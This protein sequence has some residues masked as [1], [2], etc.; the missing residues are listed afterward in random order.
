MGVDLRRA[1]AVTSLLLAL[2][3]PARA[4][5]PR[6]FAVVV[7]ANDPGQAALPALSYADDDAV[8]NAELL[9]AQGAEVRLLSDLDA[10][11]SRLYPW[12][13]ARAQ[14]PTRAGVLGA[15]RAL[16]AHMTQAKQRGESVDFFFVY[17][18]HG[19]VA[20][21]GQGQL[22]LADGAL[23]RTDLYEQLLAPSPA[24]FNHVIVDAC[25]AYEFVSGRGSDADLDR[26]LAERA[27]RYLDAQSLDRFPNT[28]VI[29]A[30][31]A[32]ARTHEWSEYQGGVFSHEVRSALLGAADL[33][34]DGRITYREAGAFV[35][36][37]NERVTHTKARLDV[38]VHPPRRAP[39]RPLAVWSGGPSLSIERPV[40]GH[41]WLE[42]ERGVRIGEA[43]K[44]TEQP[45][46]LALIPRE[47]YY[48]TLG[49]D[50]Y[51]FTA[52]GQATVRF[53]DLTR[54]AGPSLRAR[55]SIDDAFRRGL[56]AVPFGHASVEAY[57][58]P[59]ADA[60]VSEITGARPSPSGL[61]TAGY[62]LAIGAVVAGLTSAGCYLASNDAY[63]RF[64][65]AETQDAQ[66]RWK[67]RTTTYDWL[68]TIGGVAALTSAAGAAALL[69]YDRSHARAVTVGIGPG[70]LH[71]RLDF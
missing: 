15:A 50:E 13:V 69:Y 31:S 2:A 32:S 20:D 62:G 17:S 43:H 66:S 47:R 25:H 30:T 67:S 29:V 24:D 59:A 27:R 57:R 56:F 26:R 51:T 58:F 12:A 44:S 53:A 41:L 37:A 48:L 4:Q 19:G 18:G 68:T 60:A 7:G 16:F 35:A 3:A 46:T 1:L 14:R 63:H 45:L 33:D 23:T 65:R 39:S 52:P 54:N 22:L 70:T 36:A 49:A 55:G 40:A 61:R 42:D 71:A 34:G 21:S 28:G 6:R 8:R 10:E 9:L 5:T 11:T 64:Q 38:Y